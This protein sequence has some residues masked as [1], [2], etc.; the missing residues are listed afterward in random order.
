VKFRIL[1]DAENEARAAAIWYDEQLA[2]LGDDFLNDLV[3]T[4]RK[5]EDDPARFPKLETAKSERIRRCRF[6]R[7]PYFLVFE[8]LE[9]EVVVLA[10]AHAKRGPNYWRGK[11]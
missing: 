11:M 1:S 9:A 2:G 4:L 7:F 3:V 10:V 6:N 8:I 5:V